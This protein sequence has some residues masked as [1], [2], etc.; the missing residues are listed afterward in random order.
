[1]TVSLRRLLVL[2]GLLVATAASA[3]GGDRDKARLARPE[4][5]RLAEELTRELLD[6]RNAQARLPRTRQARAQADV[7]AIARERHDLLRLLLESDPDD[8]LRLALPTGIRS[9]FPVAARRWLEREVAA[10]G[11]LEVIHV[12]MPGKGVDYYT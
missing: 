7:A 11:E 5:V 10:E 8:V 2:L 4:S 12:D 3:H 1:M 6:T 9:A